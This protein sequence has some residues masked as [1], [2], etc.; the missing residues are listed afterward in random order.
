MARV[1]LIVLLWPVQLIVFL[2]PVQLI[3]LQWPVQLAVP[4]ARAV[5]RV[6]GPEPLIQYI[7]WLIPPVNSWLSLW[8]SLLTLAW[9]VRAVGF[10]IGA[11]TSIH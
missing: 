10:E 11:P 4:L 2:W 8:I 5:G 9:L 7:F 3:V 1:Q 6:R